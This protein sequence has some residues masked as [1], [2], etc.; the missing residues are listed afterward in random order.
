[1]RDKISKILIVDGMFPNK[2]TSWRNFEILALMEEFNTDIFVYKGSPWAGID[3]EI[4]YEYMKNLTDLSEYNFIIFD[5][6]YNFLQKF[7]S[8]FDGTIFNGKFPGTYLLTKAKEFDIEE[9]EVIYHIFLGTLIRFNNDFKISSSHQICH[10]YPGGGFGFHSTDKLSIE[11]TYVSTHPL[12]S[13]KCK[14]DDVKF[15]ETYVTPQTG[16]REVISVKPSKS[17]KKLTVCFSS[18]GYA[19]EKGARKFVAISIL[20]KLLF[21][22]HQ[23]Q[24]IAIGN[25]YRVFPIK[26]IAPMDFKALELFYLNEV[27][28]QLNLMSKAAT[29]GWPLG[30]EAVKQGAVLITTDPNEAS[31]RYQYGQNIQISHSA[32]GFILRIRRMYSKRNEMLSWQEKGMEFFNYYC[33]FQNQQGKV[34]KLIRENLKN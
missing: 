20:Y 33:S 18:M 15:I 12:T 25:C 16:L 22:W 11:H 9:Y 26:L 23:I 32:L 24:F 8:N 2:F 7:N 17:S 21:P 14:N 10:L 3:Y 28:I 6:A 34:I 5:P 1:M 13:D 19:K 30:I 27:D 31:K 29:N 4:D